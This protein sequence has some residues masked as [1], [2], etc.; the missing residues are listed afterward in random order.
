ML[1]RVSAVVLVVAFGAACSGRGHSGA[2]A[3]TS[4]P[5]LCP[6]IAKLDAIAANVARADVSDPDGFKRTLDAAVDEYA[7]TVVSL[8]TRVPAA[9]RPDVDR[10]ASDVR[11]YRFDTARTDRASLDEYARTACG[12]APSPTT[13]G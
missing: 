9:I 7:A 13:A 6:L 11:Q 2:G 5:G 4:G 12:R 8:R 1:Q 3:R 10:V